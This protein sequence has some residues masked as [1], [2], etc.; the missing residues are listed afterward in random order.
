MCLGGLVTY[1]SPGD[2]GMAASDAYWCAGGIVGCALTMVVCY[3]GYVL[4]ALQMGMRIRLSCASL[5]YKKSLRLTRSVAIDGT[6]GQVI[7]LMS[8]DVARFD[9]F[10][11]LLHDLWKGPLELGLMGY[12]IY[13]EI[14]AYG[15]LGIGFLLC[16]LPVQCEF[17]GSRH[18]R[19][20]LLEHVWF[21]FSA[22][23]SSAAA[24]PSIGCA[25]R[26]APTGACAS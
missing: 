25:R 10:V 15:L 17:G 8:N 13:R 16:F 6:N 1:F 22:Q 12:C 26:R 20:A 21:F 4:Y 24:P 14:G 19:S 2:H 18:M 11:S 7:N 3:H 23:P 9:P 5:V